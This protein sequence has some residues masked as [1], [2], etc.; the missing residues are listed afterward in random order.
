MRA[1]RNPSY[2][3]ESPKI[4]SQVSRRP[5]SLRRAAGNS[6][7]RD[8]LPQR[9][10]GNKYG[11]ENFKNN[12]IYMSNDNFQKDRILERNYSSSGRDP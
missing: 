8:A 2:V 5:E 10:S 11:L 1:E 6:Q 4:N 7:S 3:E 9:D 12:D